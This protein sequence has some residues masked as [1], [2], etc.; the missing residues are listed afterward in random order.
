M[1]LIGTRRRAG[2]SASFGLV[3]VFVAGA[4]G[5]LGARLV[6][7]LVAAGHDVAGMT[8]SPSKI[9]ALRQLG[10]Q[11]VC[12]D[13]FDHDALRRAVSDYA[14]DAVIHQLTDLPD[15]P[16]HIERGLA[17]NARIREEGTAN[18]VAAARAA[19]ASRLV[20]QSIAWTIN[21]SL[22]ASVVELER[23]TLDAGG[24]VVR[25]GHWYGPG[26]Y[27]EGDPPP[28]PRVH[29]DTA[30]HCTLAAL[31]LASGTYVATDDGL[32]PAVDG[33]PSV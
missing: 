15:D 9:D 33:D 1:R 5:V 17:A 6:P 7:L 16:K 27:H 26:T 30:A 20:V 8:R 13:V 11:A 29:I 25:Y 4:S 10:A 28:E 24:V 32:A 3:R 21:G 12:C 19:G 22:P 23:I 31:E 18:L 14:P 2:R